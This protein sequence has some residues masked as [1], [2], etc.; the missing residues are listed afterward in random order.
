LQSTIHFPD[1][2]ACQRGILE[3]SGEPIHALTEWAFNYSRPTPLT[4]PEN[5]EYNVKH[6]KYRADYH[7]LMKA[8]GVDFILCP[9]YLGVAAFLGTSQYWRYTGIWNVLD[10]QAAIF[11]TGLFQ[12]P[13]VDRD[14]GYAPRNDDEKREWEKYKPELYKGAPINLQLVGKHFKDEETLAAAKIGSDIIQA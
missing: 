11:P 1:G 4:I 13:A 12:D 3:E 8:R 14:D 9:T 2:A 6:E 10:Q 7:A 5:W